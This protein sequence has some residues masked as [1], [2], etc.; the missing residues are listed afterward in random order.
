MGEEEIA[1][2]EEYKYLGCIVDEHGRC[3]RMVEERA[4]AGAVALSD[5]LRRCRA[6]VGEVRGGTFGKLLEMLVG[7]VLLYGVE[8][9]G[10]ERQR[11]P[12][13]EVQMRVVR[14]CMGVWRLHPL[15][16][17]QFEMN[18]LPVKWKAMKRI[19]CIEFWVHVM[20]LGEGRL[21][22]EVVREAMKFG[23]RVNR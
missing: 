6:S 21:L 7:L 12:I 18:M 19:T 11:R 17:L 15:A 22:K 9:W 13:E 23:G 3:R 10:C 2:V 1:V 16:S 14:I 5:W 4:K 8:V 20:R